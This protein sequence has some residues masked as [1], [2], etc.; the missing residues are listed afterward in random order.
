MI[1]PLAQ[2][3]PCALGCIPKN[4]KIKDREKGKEFTLSVKELKK[5]EVI[6]KRRLVEG[7]VMGER[8]HSQSRDVIYSY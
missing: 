1:Q 6:K 3:I 4:K 7:K 5:K 2:E 8:I